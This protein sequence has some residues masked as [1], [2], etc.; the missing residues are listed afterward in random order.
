MD[1]RRNTHIIWLDIK[2][3]TTK[4]SQK[5]P[6]NQ[7][8]YVLTT[9]STRKSTFTSLSPKMSEQV[10]G[11]GYQVKRLVCGF[12]WVRCTSSHLVCESHR[13]IAAGKLF[14]FW[15]WNPQNNTNLE[16]FT[17][18]ISLFSVATIKTEKVDSLEGFWKCTLQKLPSQ[19]CSAVPECR[20]L[21]GPGSCTRVF[22]RH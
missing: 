12:S 17:M 5:T 18:S 15:L 14:H 10:R 19:P 20:G 9:F 3:I 6:K 21:G 1:N 13:S 4:I 8:V 11:D 2:L 22:I 16:L 7:S